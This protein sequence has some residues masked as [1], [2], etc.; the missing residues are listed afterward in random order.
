MLLE[1]TEELQNVLAR[2]ILLLSKMKTVVGQKFKALTG[3][4]D[5]EWQYGPSDLILS[6]KQE[7]DSYQAEQKLLNTV[8]NKVDP[9][10]GLRFAPSLALQSNEAKQLDSGTSQ[11]FDQSS[12]K[13]TVPKDAEYNS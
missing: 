3:S 5:T 2:R 9:V 6:R 13:T 10:S 1:N 8:V 12:P 7:Y 4:A 11:T